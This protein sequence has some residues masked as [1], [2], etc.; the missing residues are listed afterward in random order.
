MQTR[1]RC[2]CTNQSYTNYVRTNPP[3]YYR[4]VDDCL[5][6]RKTDSIDHLQQSL[7][8]YRPNIHF[9]VEENPDHFLDTTIKQKG[10]TFTKSIEEKPG[11]LPVHFKSSTPI[12]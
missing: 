6:K 11:K 12:S 7:N 1:I 8:S 9:T 4:Y 10:S 2:Y 3:L 5:S